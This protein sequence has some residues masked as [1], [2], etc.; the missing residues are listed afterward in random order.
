[1]QGQQTT[2]KTNLL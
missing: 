2:F 1:M